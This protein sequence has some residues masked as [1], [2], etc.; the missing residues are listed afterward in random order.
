MIV[1]CSKPY[2]NNGCGGGLAIYSFKFV[3]EKGIVTLK[4]YPYIGRE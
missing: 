3:K 2:G 1:D 4:E